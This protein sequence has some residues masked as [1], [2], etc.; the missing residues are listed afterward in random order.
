MFKHVRKQTDALQPKLASC[1]N[2]LEELSQFKRAE[3]GNVAMLFGL[4]LMT[5]CLLI[6]GSVDMG[7]WLNARDQ[8][9]SAIDA[10]ILAAGRA[11]QTGSTESEALA[12]AKRIYDSNTKTRIRVMEDSVHFMVKDNGATIATIGKVAIKTPFLGFINIENLPLFSSD[13]APEATTAQDRYERY[14][15]EVALMLDVSGSMCSPCSKR[16]DMKAAAKDLV[17]ILMKSNANSEFKA[18]VAVV[19]FSGD[20]RPPQTM[21]SLITDVAAPASI[22]KSV[23]SGWKKKSYTYYKSKCVGERTGAQRYTNATPATGSYVLPAYSDS[24][25]NNYCD[26]STADTVLPLTLD[27]STVLGRIDG[28]QTGGGT[29][30]HVGTAW[31]YYMLSPSWGNVIPSISLPSDFGTKSL[32]KIAILMTDG[33][34]NLERDSDGI[35]VG[36]KGSGSSANGKTSAQQAVEICNQMKNDGIEIYTVGFDLGGNYTAISTLNACATDASHNYLADTGEQLK[37]AFRDIAVKL[38]D[39]YV[40]K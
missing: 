30:G 29:A 27:K 37:Q 32:K 24:S 34:Y 10:A 2:G 1:L 23:K 35:T 17:E 18:R 3:H 15:R 13:E 28:L 9:F 14:N 20:V 6:G 12:L 31:A 7:R 5:M 26:I 38:T 40:S 19:P 11:I 4:M 39:L 16:D 33:E 22:K 25:S 36:D 21:L 8:T